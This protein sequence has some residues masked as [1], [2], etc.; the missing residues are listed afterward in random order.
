MKKLLALMLSVAMV[1][2]MGTSVM[3]Y[4]DVEEG[5]YVSEAV[6]VLSNLDILNG[7]EDGTFK[8]EATITRAE[9]AKIVCETLGYYGMGSDKTPF[10]DVEPKHW[11]AGYINTA[12]GLGIINGY[13]NGKFGPEDT[14]TYEQAVKM[15]VCALGYEPMAADRGGWSAGYTSVAAN[16]G[17]T[18]GMSS[19]ARGDI[20]VLIYNALTTPVMEQTSYG[21]DAR[22]E[23]LDG[24]GNKEYKTILTKQDIYIA[25]GIVGEKY[26][27]DEIAFDITKDSKDNE[28]EADHTARFMIGD[29]NI[30]DYIHQEVEVYVAEEDGDYTVLGVKAAKT[31]EIFTLVSDDIKDISGNKIVYYTNSLNSSRTKTLTIDKN[32]TIEF[33]KVQDKVGEDDTVEEVLMDLIYDDEAEA[34]VED[35]EIVLIENDDDN[36]YD[37]VVMTLYTSTLVDTVDA[38]KDKMS[39]KGKTITFDFDDEYKTYI[40]IDDEGN[41][42][43]L[44]DFEEDDVVAYVADSDNLK[45]ADYIKIVKLSNSVISGTVESVHTRDQIVTINDEDYKVTDSAVWAQISKP[46]TE[47]TFYV[48]LTGKIV[49][50]DGST[51]AGKYGYIIDSGTEGWDDDVVIEMLTNKGIDRYTLKDTV[52]FDTTYEGK[53]VEYKINSK[54]LISTLTVLDTRDFADAEYNDG[55]EILNG[56]YLDNSTQIFV[57]DEDDVDESYVTNMK[58]LVDEGEY[59]GEMFI[60]Y[61]EVKVVVITGSTTKYNSEAGFAIVTGT[62]AVVK[63]D[64]SVFAVDYV[65][66]EVEGTIYFED[67]TYSEG[68]AEFPTGT[69]FVFKADADGY[70]KTTGYKI[71]ATIDDGEFDEKVYVDEDGDKIT[72]PFGKDVETVFGYIENDSREANTK[73]ELITVDGDTYVISTKTNKYTYDSGRSRDKIE[74]EDF[75]AGDAYYAEYD[76]GVMVEATPV[77]LKLVD[78]VVVDIYTISSRINTTPVVE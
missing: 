68:K 6:T 2:T 38:K 75:L 56:K 22:Y 61:G 31:S 72:E 78:G 54:G 33:N 77:M 39:L 5:T 32:A 46:G 1:L 58:Y 60:D 44:A 28:F 10:D 8:P 30:A 73:G 13:G 27:A 76:K 49:Y 53:L 40:F 9:M 48:G 34:F 21:S 26:N 57:I 23:V 11:A 19:S 41:E 69:V 66:D 3:A 74:V 16:I 7:Y 14:V 37:V 59:T 62:S 36:S 50:F 42:L 4:S 20:A 43:T 63:D 52:D 67:F 71:V 18:K 51:V 55:T 65:Q 64:D 24:A 35:V 15:V 47:G 12:A 29:S 45:D 17:L 70:V 25:T